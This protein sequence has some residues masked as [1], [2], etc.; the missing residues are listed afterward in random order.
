[1]MRPTRRR[2][3][4]VVALL[5][6]GIPAPPGAQLG[7]PTVETRRGT[8]RSYEPETGALVLDEGGEA[9]AF[10]LDGREALGFRGPRLMRLEGLEPGTRVEID[11]VAGGGS[12]PPAVRW[13]E[14][15]PPPG[16]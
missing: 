4:A 13:L 9:R 12:S 6:A 11:Y 7:G 2:A 14:V 10:R 16:E 3:A 1:M 5:I 8:V 15:L